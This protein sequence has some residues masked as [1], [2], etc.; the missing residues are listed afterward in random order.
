MFCLII[1]IRPQQ[2]IPHSPPVITSRYLAAQVRPLVPTTGGAG[3]ARFRVAVSRNRN[4]A[5][6]FPLA[7]AAVFGAEVPGFEHVVAVQGR[8]VAESRVDVFSCGEGGCGEEGE[9]EERESRGGGEGG[10]LALVVHG[11]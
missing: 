6:F 1:K 3:Q 2:R 7:A 4:A 5:C 9:G 11:W 8:D 10:G